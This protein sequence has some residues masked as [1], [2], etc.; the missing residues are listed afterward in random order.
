MRRLFLVFA[1]ALGIGVGLV[2]GVV[3]HAPLAR[4]L[5]KLGMSVP[6]D[7]SSAHAGH[8]A[9]D[10]SSTTAARTYY[11]PM[12]PNYRSDR[13]GNCPICNMTLV[14]LE[15]DAAPAVDAASTVAGHAAITLSPEKKQ[16]IGVRVDP[17]QTQ[18][19]TKSIRAAGRVEASE[20]GLSAVTL[21]YRG[22]IEKL[23]VKSSGD[24]VHRGDPLLSIYSPEL[25]E[26]KLNYQ[27]ARAHA[28]VGDQERADDP[29]LR[30]ARERLRLWDV[31]DEQI[32]E[33][34][35]GSSPSERTTVQARS[36]GVVLRR[37]VVEGSF[38]EPGSTLLG[39]ADLST[40]WIV[41]D[42]HAE[43]AR[44]LVEGQEAEIEVL[45]RGS[46]P[47]RGK[48]E[49]VYPYLD[50]ATRT[51]RLRIEADNASGQLRPGAYS[52]VA[53]Q[54]D[55]GEHVVIDDDA[56][57]DTGTRQLVF[58]EVAEG[59]FDPR[60]VKLGER[61]GGHALVLEGLAAGEKV[62]TSGA[63][64]VDSESRIKAAIGNGTRPSGSEHPAGHEHQ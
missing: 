35:A 11:C 9:A 37:A 30:S 59:R 27:V 57:L 51:V 29:A 15:G 47:I 32:A 55:L 49:R 1:C 24:V 16:L 17:A 58:V 8:P 19:F 54:V 6:H 39:L 7:E 45:P 60:E 42:V 31:T 36:D 64:L 2:G 44:D 40:V 13:P 14:P 18:H 63:F 43:D 10:A 3:W 38:V 46:D 56:V 12:H 61:S 33:L 53:V 21:K 28:G 62:V 20:R 22:W 41:A 34:D 26:A 50:E 5:A 23:L 52:T 4:V 48:V 25:Y